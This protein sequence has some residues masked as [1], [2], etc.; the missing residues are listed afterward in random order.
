MRANLKVYEAR[1]EYEGVD[2]HTRKRGGVREKCSEM[3][4]GSTKKEGK[5]RRSWC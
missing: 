2:V 4:I 3:A 1:E 5:R